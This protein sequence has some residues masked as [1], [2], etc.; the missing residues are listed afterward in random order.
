MARATHADWRPGPE[1]RR[2]PPARAALDLHAH[3]LPDLEPVA[4]WLASWATTRLP[5]DRVAWPGTPGQ[6]RDRRDRR[7]AVGVG[8]N[9]TASGRTSATPSPT[10]TR[11]QGQR[12]LEDVGVAAV[13]PRRDPVAEPDELAHERRRRGVVHLGRRSQLLEPARVH[14]ADPVRDGQRLLLVV[15]D[16]EGGG[17]D[18]EL[19]PPDLV[20]ELDPHLRVERRERLVEQ[21]HRRLDGQRPGQRHALLL[22]AGELVGVARPCARRARRGRACPRRGS[23]GPCGTG[24]A[25]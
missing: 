17:P 4:A 5:S 20:A 9:E 3:P 6:E 12:G 8:A 23:A 21:Q 24:R 18:V 25:A 19:D 16:E 14:H 13:D 22:A 15:G 7:L 10:P 2:R 1:V 11:E